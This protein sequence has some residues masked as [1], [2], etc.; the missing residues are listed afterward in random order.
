MSP[1]PTSGTPTSDVDP[2]TESA[3]IDPY[4]VY[5]ELRAL[6]P[7][8]YLSRHGLHALPRYDEV[9]AAL[10]DWQTFSSARGVF[11]DPEV[12]ARLEGITLCSDPP[13]HTAM[14]SVL[15]RPPRPDRMRE[16]TPRSEAEA[17]RVVERLVGRGRFEV[18]TELAEYLPMTVVS[19]LVGLPDHGREKML[20]W[21]EAIWNTQGPADDRAAAA[22]PA[23]EE[24]M[25]FAVHDAVP[26]KIDP[27]GWA[28]QLYEAA[29]RGEIPHAKCPA[30]MLDYVTPSLDTTILAIT[31]AVALSAENPDQWDLLRAD[32]SLIPHAINESLRLETPAPQFGRVLTEDHETG[33]VRLAAGSRVALLHASANR[34]ERHYPDPARFDITRRPSDH[35]A[36]GRGEHVCVGMHLA[37]PE[38]SALLTRLADRVAGFGVLGRRPLINNGSRGLDRLEVAIRPAT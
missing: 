15:G 14:R 12:N 31:N 28:A 4:D 34:D 5:A 25:A 3:R 1:V 24:F 18:V 35:L 16:V 36:F 6:G 22:G 26:G 33:G 29:D 27:D 10:M 32:R 20:E 21:A 38:M 23:V 11:V 7:V 19:D 30:R 17:D 2:Y 9:R 37:R 8:V 13:E